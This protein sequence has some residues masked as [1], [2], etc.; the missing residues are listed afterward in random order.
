[1]HTVARDTLID[2]RYR[3]QRRLGAGGMAEVW[4]AQD[5][6]LGRRVA[7]KLMGGRFVE[8]PEFHE[9]FRREAQA[10][11]GLTHPNIVAIF[12]R[13]EWDGTPY[14]A[15]ELVDGKT[16]KELV[17]ERGPLPAD[18]AVGL[19]EQVLRALGYA[20]RRGI[21]HRDVKPQNVIVDAD[22]Q[23][24]VADFGIARAGETSEMTQTGAIVGTMQYLSPEQ[25][26]GRPVD[27]RADLYSAGVVLYEL[28]TG[29][30]PFDGEA[31]I[32]I[33]IKHINERPV[34]PGQLERGISP[35]LEAVVMR[36]LEKD[37]ARRFQ[38]AEE[39]IAALER[40]RHAPTREIVMEP[41]PGEPWEDE[42]RRTRW[43]VWALV[44]FALAA[45]A[46][47]AYLTIAGNK[48]D[49]PSLKGRTASEAA[50]VAHRAGLEI[51]FVAQVSDDVPR[52]E[53]I[54]QDP[55]AGERVKEGSTVTAFISSGK[56]EAPV[57]AVVGQ[58]ESD[59]VDAVTAAGF[60]TKTKDAF[61]D[62]VAK[63]DVIST[64][65]KAG[66]SLTKGRTVTLT[67]SQG[68]E[69]ITVP[70]VV[71]LQQADAV[72]QLEQLGLTADVTEQE[73]T[74]PA[75]TVMEQD[76]P[77]GTSV[78]K[79]AAVTLTVAAERPKVPDVTTDHPTEEEA[80]A[81]LEKAG[82]KVQVRTRPDPDNLDRVSDQ[83]PA[84]GTPRSTGATVTIF[85]GS[86]GATPT[87]SAS[88]T[89]T[90]TPTPTVG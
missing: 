64:S 89:P 66:E 80:T 8:D 47:G 56:G 14:I 62:S 45:I 19:T 48:V 74:Q 76:P 25:A 52:D 39:F 57:P 53:V 75:G 10:A 20:H 86:N 85:L 38:S 15:M 42:R 16:L 83:N 69:G 73:T 7:V 41:A 72:A 21:V 23:A 36:A 59:A 6:V 49:V 31:P 28:L 33:A 67:I 32:S 88:P 4:C 9:R 30:V 54:K 61:S 12:D 18:I 58:S 17:T 35:A 44:I 90:P 82:F 84:A 43:W 50:D 24:K 34:P 87:P 81:I 77:S 60:K 78:N 1:M 27:R 2:G 71:G 3:A 22:G 29:Q 51:T 68:S 40:A 46:L 65:P 63:G 5:E 79:G 70:K 11:A 55:A 13:S 26:E 37:P